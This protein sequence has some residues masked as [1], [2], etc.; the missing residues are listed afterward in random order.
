MLYN[1]ELKRTKTS[2][3]CMVCPHF[4]KR[5]KVCNGLGVV[6]FEQDRMGNLKDP[7]TGLPIKKKGE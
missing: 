7:K 6:C 4:D 3:D 5:H 1:L 2:V